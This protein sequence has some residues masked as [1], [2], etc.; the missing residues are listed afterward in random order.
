MSDN[1]QAGT[2]AHRIRG[3]DQ[4]L[5]AFEGWLG[6]PAGFTSRVGGEDDQ[7]L[8]RAFAWMAESRPK[9]QNHWPALVLAFIAQAE[10][11]LS[12]VGLHS[13]EFS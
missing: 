11:A 12:G 6:L 5:S 2:I 7:A 13:L 4:Q 9:K 10:E 1:Q 3:G 8:L